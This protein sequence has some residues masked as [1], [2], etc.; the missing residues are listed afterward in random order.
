MLAQFMVYSNPQ[1][2]FQTTIRRKNDDRQ[3]HK[4]DEQQKR[5]QSQKQ[6]CRS[7]C[8]QKTRTFYGGFFFLSLFLAAQR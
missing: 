8:F 1:R 2:S 5:Q 7:F 3:Q 4:D 6:T